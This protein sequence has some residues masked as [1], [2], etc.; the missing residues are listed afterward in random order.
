MDDQVS[1]RSTADV[2]IPVIALALAAAIFIVDWIVPAGF[3]VAVLYVAVVLLAVDFCDR[4]GVLLV[5]GVCMAL[6][7]VAYLL[8][9]GLTGPDESKIRAAVSLAAITLTTGPALRNQAANAALRAQAE[10]LDLTHD[11]VFVRDIHNVITY[12]NRGAE[13]MYGWPRALA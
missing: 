12:W 11:T 9:H 13:E 7:V 1:G 5:S 10:L 6:T 4:R 2:L 8:E 3:A